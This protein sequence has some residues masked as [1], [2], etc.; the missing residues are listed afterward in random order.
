MEEND[1]K[2][3]STPSEMIILSP[4]SNAESQKYFFSDTGPIIA[5]PVSESVIQSITNAFAEG[6]TW[7][8][9]SC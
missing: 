7:I 6:V 5:L 3:I 4:M 8:S 2:S 1:I 9:Q